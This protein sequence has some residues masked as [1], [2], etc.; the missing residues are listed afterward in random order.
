V[1]PPAVVQALNRT[2]TPDELRRALTRE[3]PDDER[4]DVQALIRWFT[5]RYPSPEARLAYVRQ[6]YARWRP[7]P[8]G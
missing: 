1:I 8:A 3:I 7:G 2:V 6:A 4:E 5:T